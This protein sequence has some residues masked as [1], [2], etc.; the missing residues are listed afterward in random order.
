M[1]GAYYEEREHGR[2]RSINLPVR[3]CMHSFSDA[4][5]RVAGLTIVQGITPGLVIRTTIPM[6]VQYSHLKTQSAYALMSVVPPTEV[7]HD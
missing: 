3:T 5:E 4:P 1:T 2:S 6:R 7:T